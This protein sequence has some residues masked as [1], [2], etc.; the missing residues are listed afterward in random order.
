MSDLSTAAFYQD[1]NFWTV[2]VS[3]I[4]ITLSQL[5]PL[6]IIFRRKKLLIETHS[7]A[8]VT[9]KVGNPNL[10]LYVGI[11]NTGGRTIRITKL[12]AKIIRDNMTLA[13]LPAKAYIGISKDA[14]PLIFTPFS[15]KP[16]EAWAYRVNFYNDFPRA[17][18]IQFRKAAKELREEIH[19]LLELK[20]TDEKGPVSASSAFV[21]PFNEIFTKLFIWEAGE[22]TL[23]VVPTT[24]PPI[25][26]LKESL[27]FTIYE[28]DRDTL[29]EELKDYPTGAG[30][31]FD[32]PEHPGL[33]VELL[34]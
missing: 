5:P 13:T 4:A 23:E 22:Y 26:N 8:H 12:T 25:P 14:N 11:T 28:S 1:F 31:N 2:L 24:T 20:P 10:G 29:R 7:R 6:H 18:D 9:H 30:I 34:K 32:T 33:S 19:K 15:L 27:R 21:A 16:E 3:C 17:T